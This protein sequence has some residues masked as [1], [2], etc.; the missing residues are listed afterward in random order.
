MRRNAP[1]GSSQHAWSEKECGNDDPGFRCAPSGLH[2]YAGYEALR[3]DMNP[4]LPAGAA[5]ALRGLFPLRQTL[6]D[7][8]RGFRRRLAHVGVFGDLALDPLALV[9]QVVTQRL[10]LGD[11]LFDLQ[12]RRPGNA[13]DQRIEIVHPQFA[14]GFRL[15]LSQLRNVPANELADIAFAFGRRPLPILVSSSDH[16]HDASPLRREQYPLAAVNYGARMGRLGGAFLSTTEQN[17]EASPS[18]SLTPH[19]PDDALICATLTPIQI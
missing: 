4:G 11:E 7:D 10:Q 19:S 18:P 12:H 16:G 17:A 9:L 15:R 14:A 1:H 5:V 8:L 6:G 2:L 13:L 3:R